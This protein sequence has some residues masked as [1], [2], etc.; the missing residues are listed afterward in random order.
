MTTNETP[1]AGRMTDSQAA[2]LTLMLI[3]RKLR[4]MAPDAF[5]K[6]W[7]QLPV[8]AQRTVTLAENRADLL[9]DRQPGMAWPTTDLDDE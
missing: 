4:R 7:S 3:T 9:R 8:E 6:A 2:D 5:A 1:T